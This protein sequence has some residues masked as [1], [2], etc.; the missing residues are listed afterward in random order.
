M[1]VWFAEVWFVEV[2]FEEVSC[3]LLLLRSRDLQYTRHF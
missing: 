3:G 1:E 2:W